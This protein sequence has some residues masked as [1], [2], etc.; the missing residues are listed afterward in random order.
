MSASTPLTLAAAED[1][2]ARTHVA[3]NDL[4]RWIQQD[5][6]AVEADRERVA[7]DIEGLRRHVPLLMYFDVDPAGLPYCRACEVDDAWP[8]PDARRYSDGL[9][10]TAA[11]YRVQP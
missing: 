4:S 3:M 11:L 6:L 9:R 5:S 10:R 8:C 2:A 7:S 1:L